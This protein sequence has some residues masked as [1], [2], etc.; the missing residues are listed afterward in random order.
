MKWSSLIAKNGKH[1]VLQ[2]KKFGRFDSRFPSLF[3]SN[4]YGQHRFYETKNRLSNKKPSVFLE[5]NLR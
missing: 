4:E 3:V 5:L 2:R 1:S